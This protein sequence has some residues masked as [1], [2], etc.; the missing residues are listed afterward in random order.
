M[1]SRWD[2]IWQKHARIAR[3]T[4]ELNCVYLIRWEIID[5]DKDVDQ[6]RNYWLRQGCWPT[7]LLNLQDLTSSNISDFGYLECSAFRICKWLS[8]KRVPNSASLLL[9]F[10][11]AF[12]NFPKIPKVEMEYLEKF[13]VLTDWPFL[14]LDGR[15]KFFFTD[16]NITV[17]GRF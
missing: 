3:V 13:V 12:A 17:T 10:T 8:A 9:I 16:F 14:I 11:W 4:T 5:K 1:A 7:L 6:L 2:E 15:A